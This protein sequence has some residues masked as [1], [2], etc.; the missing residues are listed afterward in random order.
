MEDH[1]RRQVERCR[2]CMEQLSGAEAGPVYQQPSTEGQAA[3]QAGLDGASKVSAPDRPLTRRPP[4]RRP[5]IALHA[6]QPGWA[7]M[8]GFTLM[9]PSACMRSTHTDRSSNRRICEGFLHTGS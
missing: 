2:S 3:A 8:A 9:T 5:R 1:Y 7:H 4:Q 6:H